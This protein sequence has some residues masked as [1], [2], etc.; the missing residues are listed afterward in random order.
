MT[1]G[2]ILA[3]NR[4]KSLLLL[5]L[6]GVAMWIAS[7]LASEEYTLPTLLLGVFVMLVFFLVFVKTIRFEAGVL[8]F[9]LAGYM[10][11]NR[12]FAQLSVVRPLF[13]G[14]TGMVIMTISMI[15]RYI[16]ARNTVDLTGTL[17]RLILAYIFLALCHFVPDV[18]VYRM[19]A[20]R[21]FAMVYYSIFFF[22]GRELGNHPESKQ[23]LEKC[24]KFGVLGLA[25]IAII[26]RFS[27]QTLESFTIAGVPFLLQKDD[28]TTVFAAVAVFYLYCHPDVFRWKWIRSC[29]ILFFIVFVVNG[30]TRASLAGFMAGCVLLAAAGQRRFFVYP[31]VAVVLGVTLLAGFATTFIST[32]TS[33]PDALIDKVKSMGNFSGEGSSAQSELAEL[34]ANNNYFRRTLWQ[35]FLDETMQTAPLMGRGFGYDFLPRYQDVY[36]LG[37]WQG[38]RSAHNFYVTLFGRMGIIGS[39]VFLA[40]TWQVIIGGFRAARVMRDGWMD[41]RDLTYWCSAWAILVCATF[42]VVLEGPM[43]AIIFWSFLGLGTAALQAAQAEHRLALDDEKAAMALT[44]EA[45]APPG[46]FPL[47]QQPQSPALGGAAR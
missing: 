24:I 35:S 5:P 13:V 2:F 16:L 45:S 9:L 7:E 25:P 30:I 44:R 32:Q 29:L 6:I 33:R 39:L 22:F 41:L 10:I 19:D 42:G 28:L 31:A 23:F 8:G 27:Q 11:G 37:E 36:R 17:A 12:G 20:V 3:D 1:P 26:H 21:D 34:K 40:I 4:L 47:G 14:E 46:E 18:K 15:V 43:G 38:L